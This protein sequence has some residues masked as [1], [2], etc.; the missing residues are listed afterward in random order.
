MWC[1]ILGNRRIF[2]ENI[3]KKFMGFYLT[4]ILS[5]SFLFIYYLRIEIFKYYL[6]F[7]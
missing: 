6:F 4:K 2:T 1:N 5:S 7:P 3:K